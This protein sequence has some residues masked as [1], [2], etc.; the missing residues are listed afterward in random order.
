MATVLL[1]PCGASLTAV[2]VMLLLA[3]VLLKALLPP[4]TLVLALLPAL[5]LVR[6]Q[7]RKL[8]PLTTA[9]FQL[10]AGAKRTRVRV[11]AASSMALV[12]VTALKA[13][14][15]LPPLSEYCQMPLVLLTAVTAMPDSAP[16][17]A[18]LTRPA[19]SA[20]TSVPLSATGSSPM[21]ARSF[22][23]ERTGALLL[24]PRYS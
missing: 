3:T 7:A 18:S 19:I 9:P 11:S 21:F 10:A 14:Q 17:S 1:V 12:A 8:M 22:A 15:L 13:V 20:D 24:M 6:S 5:P 2:T 4:L 16:A 23:P